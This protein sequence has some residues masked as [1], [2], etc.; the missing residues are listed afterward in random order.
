MIV[1]VVLAT[2]FFAAAFSRPVSAFAETV[3]SSTSPGGYDEFTRSVN[4]DLGIT[5]S[6][7]SQ[8]KSGDNNFSFGTY[9]EVE[10]Y[11][12]RIGGSGS[13]GNT[14]NNQL[15]RSAPSGLTPGASQTLDKVRMKYTLRLEN[16]DILSQVDERIYDYYI[17]LWRVNANG[18]S[19]QLLTRYVLHFN[20]SRYYSESWDDQENYGGQENNGY[21]RF[22]LAKKDYTYAN[23]SLEI[24]PSQ[25][26]VGGYTPYNSTNYYKNKLIDNGYTILNDVQFVRYVSDGGILVS[27]FTE[28]LYPSDFNGIS[29]TF[30][31]GV[32]VITLTINTDDVDANYRC[33]FGYT[34]YDV[35]ED[36]SS[37]D[38]WWWIPI[39][40]QFAEPAQTYYKKS[41]NRAGC[42]W[43]SANSIAKI[44]EGYD[45]AGTLTSH[46][47]GAALTAADALMNEKR[48]QT[49]Q[50]IYLEQIDDTPFARKVS[51]NITVP[52]RSDKLRLDTIC[53]ALNKS[54]MKVLNSNV[55]SVVEMN[56]DGQFELV[57]L[58][59]V[60]LHA[61]DVTG[62]ALDSFLNINESY[63]T[64][65][66]RQ[67]GFNIE[68]DANGR[69]ITADANP[70]KAILTLGEYEYFLNS[71][72]NEYP[73][74]AGFS[75]NEIHGYW[76]FFAIPQ[77]Y[78][79]D[80]VWKELFGSA[81]QYKG[82]ANYF[83]HN[84]TLSYD[85]YNSLLEDYG[86]GYLERLFNGV[87]GAVY[88][89]DATYYMI[90]VDDEHYVA[91]SDN[92]ST[93]P[94]NQNGQIGNDVHEGIDE[95]TNI[96]GK[97]GNFAT[98]SV[99]TVLDFMNNN[100]TAILIVVSVIAAVVVF[101]I[102]ANKFGL[103]KKKAAAR[104][105]K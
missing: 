97:V 39:V 22:I 94:D 14:G 13:A 47:S 89:Y 59:A 42:I 103:F 7:P 34:I 28:S 77:A 40:Q 12:D 87:V 26:N 60:W 88:G 75:A 11:T 104:R 29:F 27:Y 25:E 8:A 74:L 9:P 78:G 93:D 45:Q 58:S 82:V 19:E 105:K 41:L 50:I 66:N 69:I 86:H 99:N 44:I 32:P 65:Y 63:E 91:V 95:I 6:S 102:V 18:V 4:R 1:F 30:Q 3:V 33:Y 96:V 36:Y 84:V 61:A 72:K 17:D 56:G 35:V 55:E 92:G 71:I 79:I 21:K 70:S 20:N 46:Y 100:V 85:A 54:T 67:C 80:A 5:G 57:Y 15:T 68:R 43:T 101:F 52:V 2:A 23:G 98:T 73:S 83:R 38:W 62:G 16:S 90:Y 53:S 31:N 64:F 48:M 49:V 37:G 24:S 81:T 10:F 51:R 76:G